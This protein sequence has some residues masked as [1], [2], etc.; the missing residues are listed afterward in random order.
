MSTVTTDTVAQGE[1][2]AS[3]SDTHNNRGRTSNRKMRRFKKNQ[4][5][6]STE[7]FK[8]ATPG[9]NGHAF[10]PPRVDRSIRHDHYVKT[11]EAIEAYTHR[12]LDYAQDLAGFFLNGTI[13]ELKATNEPAPEPVTGTW[14]WF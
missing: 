12:H 3:N 4:Q 6:K 5:V 14:S 2:V 7:G 11:R 10:V 13:S 1:V 9:L 8:G